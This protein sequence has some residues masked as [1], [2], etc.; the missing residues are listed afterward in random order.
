MRT[1]TILALSLAILAGIGVSGQEADHSKE[2]L[3]QRLLRLATEKITPEEAQRRVEELAG[4]IDN[5]K[6]QITRLKAYAKEDTTSEKEARKI[7]QDEMNVAKKFAK[8][9]A[10]AS[11]VA[12]VR[13]CPEGTVYVNPGVENRNRAASQVTVSVVNETNFPID[14]ETSYVGNRLGIGNLCPHGSVTLSFVLKYPETSFVQQLN[15]VL[16]AIGTHAEGQRFTEQMGLTL[17]NYGNYYGSFYT[18]YQRED[19]VWEIR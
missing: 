2:T 1:I 13:G 14:I 6:N 5:A 7:L 9:H 11:A 19:R 10:K 12:G 17:Q 15:I 18:N 4:K 3:E 8:A 16:L